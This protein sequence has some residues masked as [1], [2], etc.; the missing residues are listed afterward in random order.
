MNPRIFLTLAALGAFL[1][2]Q[3][4]HAETV[5]LKNGREL[6]AKVLEE[7]ATSYLLEVRFGTMKVAK[8]QVEKLLEGPPLEL[9]PGGGGG[10]GQTAPLPPDTDKT[11]A[12]KSKSTGKPAN[13]PNTT[14]NSLLDQVRSLL[15]G[16][17]VDPNALKK[18]QGK[19]PA[20][21][22][23]LNPQQ[24]KQAL[25]D[26]KVQ[27]QLQKQDQET[28]A[29]KFLEWRRNQHGSGSR[30]PVAASAS[31]RSG[32]PFDRLRRAIEPWNSSAQNQPSQTWNQ[33]QW[34]QSQQWNQNQLWNQQVQPWDQQLQNYQQQLR[35]LQ[36]RRDRI[37]RQGGV[38]QG[39]DLNQ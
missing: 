39:L 22:A 26:P 7:D 20:N 17:N 8:E 27:A 14:G 34:N 35:A 36:N 9:I 15:D 25:Q 23:K 37:L 12:P 19:L 18:L 16:G 1:A 11:T 33:N 32:D 13:Q 24:L 38:I 29:E 21:L 28:W 2:G 10:E 31:Q 30:A 4:C 3:V 6:L 5:I